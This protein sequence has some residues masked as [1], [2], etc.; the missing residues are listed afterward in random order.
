MVKLSGVMLGTSDAKKLGDFYT[1]VFGEP[2]WRKD[3]WYAFDIGGGS[4][5][6]GPHSEVHDK[7]KEPGRSMFMLESEDVPSEYNRIKGL[8]VE[9]IAEPYHPGQADDKNMWLSTFA[10]PDGNYF[11]IASPM[12]P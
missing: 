7:N 4:L 8:G 12:K 5:I 3:D 1:K 11:Q 10:D 9:I 2:N 6:I